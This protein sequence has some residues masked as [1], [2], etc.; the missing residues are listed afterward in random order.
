MNK[1]HERTTP[2]TLRMSQ[3][4]AIRAIAIF[5]AIRTSSL[6]RE[7]KSFQGIIYHPLVRY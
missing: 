5:K 3:K 2:R 6:L 1:S 4:Y 7:K